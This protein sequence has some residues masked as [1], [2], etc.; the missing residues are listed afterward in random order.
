MAHRHIDNAVEF[1]GFLKL[2]QSIL[3][4]PLEFKDGS[5]AVPAD[6][7]PKIENNVLENHTVE[8]RQFKF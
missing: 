3:S 6:Y 1:N 4:N 7:W 8:K 2:S 5:L